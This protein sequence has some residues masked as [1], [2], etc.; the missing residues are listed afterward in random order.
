MT[1]ENLTTTFTV[2]FDEEK[3][4]N[5]ISGIVERYVETEIKSAMFRENGA[6]KTWIKEA[7]YSHKDEII[8]QVVERASKEMVRKGL[9]RMLEGMKEK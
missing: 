5:M 6:I 1:N 8:E 2:V 7:L 3:V 9:N 4:K